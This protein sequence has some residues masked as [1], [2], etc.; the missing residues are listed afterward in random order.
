MK[1]FWKLALVG[2]ALA[3]SSA[4]ADVVLPNTGNGEFVLF[5]RN[6][7]TGQVYARGL[8]QQIDTIG[9]DFSGAY[10]AAGQ[11]LSF[12]FNGGNPVGPDAALTTF[13]SAAGGTF[14]FAVIAA[15][16]SFASGQSNALGAQ[17]YAFTDSTDIPLDLGTAIQ[18]TTLLSFQNAQSVMSILNGQ[19]PGAVG[20]GASVGS[21]GQW[22]QTGATPGENANEWFGSGIFNTANLGTPTAFYLVTTSGG[23]ATA[24]ARIYNAGAFQLSADGTLTFTPNAGGPPVPLPAAAWLLLSGLGGL[25]VIGRRRKVAVAA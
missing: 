22:G 1:S 11:Q 24:P 3:A 6:T 19:L 12:A 16:T 4:F 18:Q 23:A 10:T 9:T 5:V 20:N 17:R 8:V 7:A 21:N 25:G 2:T 14:D 13:L 15:D